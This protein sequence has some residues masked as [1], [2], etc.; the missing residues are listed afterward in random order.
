MSFF[1]DIGSG[2]YWVGEQ[3]FDVVMNFG[4]GVEWQLERTG[5]GALD[6]NKAE[7]YNQRF[8][9]QWVN[10]GYLLFSPSSPANPIY[11]IIELVLRKLIEKRGEKI[12]K[13]I[14]T[15]TFPSIAI[16]IPVKVVVNT[17][18]LEPIVSSIVNKL[19]LTQFFR[20]TISIFG[21]AGLGAYIT[22][23]GMVN[24]AVVSIEN[25]KH[26]RPGIYYELRAHNVDM[27]WF[28]VSG[29]LESMIKEI[30]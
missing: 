24:Q 26:Y 9:D 27:F 20:K 25:L 19:L 15:E 18:I 17:V 8:F 4:A 1:N 28:L 12:A 2:V 23:Q 6:K 22:E 11:K 30:I 3:A 29:R 14:I 13:K 16:K 7:A 10:T 5:L 21:T